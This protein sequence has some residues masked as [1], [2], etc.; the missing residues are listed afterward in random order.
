M[1]RTPVSAAVGS[2]RRSALNW[3]DRILGV[4]CVVLLVACRSTAATTPSPA[5]DTVS[6]SANASSAPSIAPSDSVTLLAGT[7]YVTSRDGIGWILSKPTENGILTLT[8]IRLSTGEAETRVIERDEQWTVQMPVLSAD[9]D[10]HLWFTYINQIQRISTE[11]G[12]IKRWDLPE[13]PADAALSDEDWSAGLAGGNVWDPD[14]DT[15]LFVRVS[16]HRL[17]RFDPTDETFTTVANLPI[18]THDLSRVSLA[19]DGT[20]AINGAR[21]DGKNY[22]R[23]AALL[24][25]SQGAQ[26]LRLGILSICMGQTGPLSIDQFGAVESGHQ[27]LGTVAFTPYSDVPFVCDAHGN[28][29][30]TGRV[31]SAD[32]SGAMILAYRFAVSGDVSEWSFPLTKSTGIDHFTGQPM[33][34]WGGAPSVETL[35]PDGEG[36]VWL[37]NIDG[38]SSQPEVG[39][40]PYPTLMRIRF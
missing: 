28:A 14:S 2:H 4:S 24:N 36:G 3:R 12:A 37:V 18:I 20:V 19:V 39:D 7:H 33:T 5:S 38:T 11:D 22:V 13:P 32:G 27:L 10:G 35:L 23:A 1:G 30:T 16:D 25:G 17:Y 15:L 6:P 34:V 29:F 8:Q 21:L 40:S 31:I 26:E 9:G